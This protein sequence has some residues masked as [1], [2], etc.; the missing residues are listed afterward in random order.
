MRA[1]KGAQLAQT[2][3][4]GK[5]W[6]IH[7]GFWLRRSEA[8]VHIISLKMEIKIAIKPK[9]DEDLNKQKKF[10]IDVVITNNNR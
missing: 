1:L 2:R 7:G 10:K 3:V 5:M 9:L 6:M 4:G 8:H